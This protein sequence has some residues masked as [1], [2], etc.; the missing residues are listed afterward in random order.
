[1]KWIIGLITIVLLF[2][3]CRSTKRATT[4]TKPKPPIELHKP[5]IY[6][7]PEQNTKVYVQLDYNGEL[8][9]TY[10]KYDE[11][12]GWR[13]EAQPNG[14]LTDSLIRWYKEKTK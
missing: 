10:P 1:M 7:Y 3:S 4:K 11:N 13:V 6:L 2:T 12:K 8:T 9:T 14:T 5:I